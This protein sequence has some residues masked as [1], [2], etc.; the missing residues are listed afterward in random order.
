MA[1]EEGR[2]TILRGKGGATIIDGS[3]NGGFAAIVAGL[4]SVREAGRGRPS[5]LL[6]GDMRE[7]GAET[8]RL[9]EAL[10]PEIVKTAPQAVVLVGPLMAAHVLPALERALPGRVRHFLS[11]RQAGKWLADNL[12]EKAP[13]NRIIFVKGSQNTIFLEEA[14][15]PM[16]HD[17]ADA[18]LLCRR[19]QEWSRRKED[20]FS[21]LTQ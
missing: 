5:V 14:L 10:V 21:S 12:L 6:L 19:G 9:H 7:L 1:P 8:V 3:Y 18:A 16:L 17:S 2:G 15:P 4:A 13:E 11:S 20:F